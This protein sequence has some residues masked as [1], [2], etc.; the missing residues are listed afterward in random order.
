MSDQPQRKPP[1]AEPLSEFERDEL[2]A[3]A[4]KHGMVVRDATDEQL[5]LPVWRKNKIEPKTRKSVGH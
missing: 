2:R 4:T 5:V 3:W 1:Q